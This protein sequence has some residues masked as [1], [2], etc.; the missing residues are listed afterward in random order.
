MSK[1]SLPKQTAERFELLAAGETKSWEWATRLHEASCHVFLGGG[2]RIRPVLALTCARLFGKESAAD[3]WAVAVELIHTYSLVHDD[4]PAMDDDDMRRGKPTCHIAFGEGTA[5]LVGDAL[6]TRAFEVISDST[7]AP[8]LKVDLIKLLASASG[9]VGMVG[10][11]VDD[12]YGDL[13]NLDALID[14]QNKKT[15]ALLVAAAVGGALCAGA[16]EK[17]LKHIRTFSEVFGLLFQLTD[18]IIDKSQDEER[19]SNNFHHHLNDEE[20]RG[21]RDRLI[22]KAHD[23]LNLLSRDTSQLA[24]LIELIGIRK[25]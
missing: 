5:V 11:Q 8:Q 1:V 16:D 13:S 23:S 2:K 21:W 24:E 10:G 9:G 15:G 14:M 12:L 3:D 19:D 17:D 7:H 4:L 25:V 20:V 18:D 6:L 22:S